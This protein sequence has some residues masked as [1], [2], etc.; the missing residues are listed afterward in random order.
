MLINEFR[1][2]YICIFLFWI[3]FEESNVLN[4][5]FCIEL[6]I[7][8]AEKK[9]LFCAGLA[10]QTDGCVEVKGSFVEFKKLK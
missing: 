3:F 2:N 9:R 1:E 8:R 6:R 4:C 5:R 7:F 10:C